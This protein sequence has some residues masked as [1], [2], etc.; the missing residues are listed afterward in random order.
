MADRSTSPF[1][2][3]GLGWG[4]SVLIVLGLFVHRAQQ[5]GAARSE[6]HDQSSKLA[7]TVGSNSP[8][9]KSDASLEMQTNWAFRF[10]KSSPPEYLGPIAQ[11]LGRSTEELCAPEAAKDS[12][13]KAVG[14]DGK[15]VPEPAKTSEAYSWANRWGYGLLP[16]KPAFLI[17]LLPDPDRSRSAYRFDLWVEA[18][19]RAANAQ[20]P[21]QPDK[22]FVLDHYYLPWKNSGDSQA[23]DP[24]RPETFPGLLVFRSVLKPK[25]T[26]EPSPA[27]TGGIGSDKDKVAND[28][29]STTEHSNTLIVFLVGDA[30]I[31][32]IQKR[33]LDTSLDIIAWFKRHADDAEY[34]NSLQARIVGPV[35]SGSQPSLQ[36]ALQAWWNNHEGIRGA[37]DQWKIDV[38]S[39]ASALEPERFKADSKLA[40]NRDF[41]LPRPADVRLRTTCVPDEVLIQA[42]LH[43]VEATEK[44]DIRIAHLRESNTGFGELAKGI[45]WKL[46]PRL[47]VID[48]PFPLH[49]SRVEAKHDEAIRQDEASLPHFEASDR[50]L[51]IPTHEVEGAADTIPEQDQLMTAVYQDISLTAALETLAKH[52]TPY[53]LISATDPRDKIFLASVVKTHCPHAR[54]LLTIGD[55]LYTHSDYVRYLA[56][57]YVASCYPLSPVIVRTGGS[58]TDWQKQ[59]E[60]HHSGMQLQSF[61]ENFAFAYY[62]AVAAHLEKRRA[63]LFYQSSSARRDGTERDYFDEPPIWLSQVGPDRAD[64]LSER[65]AEDRLEG[66]KENKG[67]KSDRHACLKA[68]DY[69]WRPDRGQKAGAQA[70][71]PPEEQ[72]HFLPSSGT[73]WWP[74]CLWAANFA[75]A[76]NLGYAWNLVGDYCEA[77]KRYHVSNAQRAPADI[78]RGSHRLRV[79]LAFHILALEV[80]G[81]I[82]GYIACLVLEPLWAPERSVWRDLIRLSMDSPL[83][84]LFPAI[85]AITLFTIIVVRDLHCWLTHTGEHVSKLLRGVMV[86]AT[87]C[88]PLLAFFAGINC[89]PRA[90]DVWGHAR[91]TNV[92]GWNSPFIPSLLIAGVVLAWCRLQAVRIRMVNDFEFQWDTAENESE[93]IHSNAPRDVA[94]RANGSYPAPIDRLQWVRPQPLRNWLLQTFDFRR[95]AAASSK[96]LATSKFM[97]SSSKAPENWID[98]RLNDLSTANDRVFVACSDFNYPFPNKSIGMQQ[99]PA[100]PWKTLDNGFLVAGIAITTYG[101]L[102]V[103]PIWSSGPDVALSPS[104]RI[105][106]TFCWVLLTCEMGRTWQIWQLLKRLHQTVARLPMQK[107]L[108]SLPEY[109][110]HYY[111][112]LVFVERFGEG[113]SPAIDQQFGLALSEHERLGPSLGLEAVPFSLE[114]MNHMRYSRE[115]SGLRGAGSWIREYCRSVL[116][117]IKEL[118]S[119]RLVKDSYACT[120]GEGGGHGSSSVASLSGPV[121][122]VRD[123]PAVM[124][125]SKGLVMQST[126]ISQSIA[127]PASVD[128]P[129]GV[130]HFESTELRHTEGIRLQTAL[131]VQ[132][133]P[134]AKQ[135]VVE[136]DERLFGM[137]LVAYLSQYR[138]QLKSLALFLAITPIM[139][140]LATASYSFAPQGRLMD[141]TALLGLACLVLL[142]AVYT[143]LNSDEFLS[144][145]SGTLPRWYAFSADSVTTFLVIMLPLTLTLASRLPGGNVIY[146]WASS[147]IRSMPSP[148]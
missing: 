36:T 25:P 71:L 77:S 136:A 3:S 24:N 48:I 10:R 34:R 92:M 6:T 141:F 103:Y 125:D 11:F 18:L 64:V 76:I 57:A 19:Q 113:N 95:P 54:L 27:S 85:L 110:G 88:T 1:S 133:D 102:S 49:I 130:E 137:M 63:L 56:G 2:V 46:H 106:I 45:D 65:R 26:A 78:E 40:N 146:S 62:N 129:V 68:M 131:E 17:A 72:L 59:P 108:T 111:G 105:G 139:L 43:F 61:G 90:D 29:R 20:D 39:T 41:L 81:G 69:L 37:A 75:L 55:Q 82:T 38:I 115:I 117:D 23:R 58:S 100:S 93:T 83:E 21:D 7:G 42:L 12:V 16:N 32:G 143:G 60:D 120:S 74:I 30:P 147:L 8:G 140:L 5:G 98:Q 145:V 138:L 44:G 142:A 97:E 109:F 135:R 144:L 119:T 4:A 15:P 94:Q 50:G 116:P 107:V 86:T 148:S 89:T 33:A 101:I 66:S 123:T 128:W 124:A 35:F 96:L 14:A 121:A 87:L 132:K 53:I 28:Q 122:E 118:W 80:F 47:D 99:S 22:N 126:A 70:A 13:G 84:T 104:L 79:Y 112:D 52:Q 134:H 91:V 127:D 114:Q 73:F 31:G 9:M 67:K 51:R